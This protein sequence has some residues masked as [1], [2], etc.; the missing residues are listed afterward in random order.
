MTTNDVVPRAPSPKAL[1]IS[2]E[3]LYEQAW[4]TPI[5]HLAEKFGVSGSY[6]A[7]VCEA[8][9]VP[10]PPVG[11]WRKKA[12]GKAKPRPELPTALPGDQL[13]WSKEKPIAVPV[14]NRV[15]RKP[16]SAVMTKT[17]RSGRHP[18][19]IGVEGHFR[20]SRKVEEGEFLRPYKYLLPD[21]VA[22]EAFLDS[23]RN[24]R[25]ECEHSVEY[26]LAYGYIRY[27]DSVIRTGRFRLLSASSRIDRAVLTLVATIARILWSRC[28]ANHCAEK[29]PHASSDH[30]ASSVAANCLSCQ[31]SRARSY[32]GTCSCPLFLFGSRATSQ[33]GREQKG[34]DDGFVPRHVHFS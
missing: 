5:N 19:L 20:K 23:V 12:V 7:R 25:Q 21:V 2:R 28:S 10:R 24:P 30:G 22:S 26:A 27:P 13:T 18:M 8:L 31:S 4:A 32:Q 15:R 9:N 3:D 14:K 33:S 1:E 29:C 16:G 17:I 11:H 34:G 6:L